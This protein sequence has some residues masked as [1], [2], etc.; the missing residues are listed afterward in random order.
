M[1]RGAPSSSTV[2]HRHRQLAS[3]LGRTVLT[4]TA[5][6]TH[7]VPYTPLPCSA[8]PVERKRHLKAREAAQA[9]PCSS[10]E[11]TP[12]NGDASKTA[13]GCEGP[14][15]AAPSLA[16]LPQKQHHRELPPFR[17]H[18]RDLTRSGAK[19]QWPR[20]DR[21]GERKPAFFQQP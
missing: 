9:L 20:G 14:G 2:G 7:P 15:W 18:R 17:Q 5:R 13:L 12:T 19:E 10:R 8:I 21:P 1:V 6:A 4:R 3:S 11:S 16:V